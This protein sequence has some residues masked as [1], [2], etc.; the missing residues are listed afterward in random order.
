MQKKKNGA[1]KR[2]HRGHHQ[3][4]DGD[5]TKIKF[6]SFNC[7]TLY[8]LHLKY[9]REIYLNLFSRQLEEGR[10]M[11]KV[12]QKVQLKEEQVTYLFLSLRYRMYFFMD[13]EQ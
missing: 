5:N 4:F 12:I 7:V 8:F 3:L 1:N 2:N 11:Q 10:K 13:L 6:A 9:K